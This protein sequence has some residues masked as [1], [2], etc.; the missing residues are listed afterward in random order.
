MIS[1][2][3]V[4]TAIEENSVPTVA[5]PNV[6]KNIT[7]NRKGLH[8]ILLRNVYTIIVKYDYDLS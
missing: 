4:L 2:E 3:R 6:A 7:P 1:R 5:N 8:M